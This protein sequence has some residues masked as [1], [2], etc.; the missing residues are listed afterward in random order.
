MQIILY[1]FPLQFH[2]PL[3]CAIIHRMRCI[4]YFIVPFRFFF[5]GVKKYFFEIKKHLLFS[6]DILQQLGIKNGMSFNSCR[7]IHYGRMF[8]SAIESA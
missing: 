5:G 3:S 1:T 7:F 6:V 8:E 4:L 2:I